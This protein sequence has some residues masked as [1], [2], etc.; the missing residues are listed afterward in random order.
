MREFLDGKKKKKSQM[1]VL[2]V[3]TKPLAIKII[4]FRKMSKLSSKKLLISQYPRSQTNTN[5]KWTTKY[6][7]LFRVV[8]TYDHGEDGHCTF[9]Q[10]ADSDSYNRLC[11]TVRRGKKP[12]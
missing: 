1:A 8:F 9:S 4:A 6:C 12:Y 10:R 5:K 7:S 3:T 2:I 11:Y